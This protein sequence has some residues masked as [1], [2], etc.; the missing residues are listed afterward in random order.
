MLILADNNQTIVTIHFEHLRYTYRLVT[1]RTL[2]YLCM[3]E[4]GLNGDEKRVQFNTC[5]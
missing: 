5:K 4:N 1:H 2:D 3:M